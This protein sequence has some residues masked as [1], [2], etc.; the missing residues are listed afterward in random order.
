VD[1][2][3]EDYD[4]DGAL[5]AAVGIVP[6]CYTYQDLRHAAGVVVAA[7]AAAASE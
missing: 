3:D 5:V 1:D 2:N 6:C 7:A 4:Y